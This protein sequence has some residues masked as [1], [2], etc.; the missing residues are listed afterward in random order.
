MA[1]ELPMPKPS[2]VTKALQLL[3]FI[4]NA[5][6]SQVRLILAQS[7]LEWA[8]RARDKAVAEMANGP[9][10]P[11]GSPHDYTTQGYTP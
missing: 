3:Q 10:A 8:E 6:P 1:A 11:P 5:M 9:Q 4:Y 7:V 2:G